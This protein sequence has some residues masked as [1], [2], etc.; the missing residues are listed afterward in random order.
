MIESITI[1]LPPIVPRET[2]DDLTR[3]ERV[4]GIK[5][6]R[7]YS[8]NTYSMVC[9]TLDHIKGLTPFSQLIVVTQSPDQLSPCMAAEI[10]DYLELP[11]DVLAFDVNHACD[12]W[13]LGAHL[14]N[15]L[16]GRTLLICA[17]RLRFGIGP[18]RYMFSDSVSVTEISA[19]NN[20]FA[21]YTDGSK[22]G[23]LV[24]GLKGEVEMRGD[25]VFDFVTSKMPGFIQDFGDSYDYLVPHQANLSM[26]KLL[27]M[28]S[29]YKDRTLYS[30][31]E[32]GNQSMNSIPTCLV[33]NS[34]KIHG[35]NVLC[36]GFGA[37]FTAAGMGMW[38]APKATRMVEI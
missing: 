11:S 28:R 21:S 23:A 32:F 10:H 4:T 29:G 27:A 13:V 37:G 1:G 9:D 33:K 8:G 15:K 18:E 12:G 36:V 30:I 16:G 25:E 38:W 3:F 7:R 19:A 17:D 35:A 22:A 14:A 5:T 2:S 34:E 31:E 26:L 6:T 24:C 20:R